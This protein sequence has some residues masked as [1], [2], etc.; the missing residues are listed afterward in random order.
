ML[1]R[2]EVKNFKCFNDNFV[3]DLT[4]VKN[5]EFNPECIQNG[6]VKKALIYGPNACGKSNLGLAIFDIKTHLS[7]HKIEEVYQQNYLNAASDSELAEFVYTFQ[8]EKNTVIYRY[9]KEA[10]DKLVYEQVE[11]NGDEVI[12]LDRRVNNIAAINLAGAETLNQ[13]LTNNPKISVLNYVQNNAVLVD[14]GTNLALRGLFD[15]PRLMINIGTNDAFRA[16]SKGFSDFVLDKKD[17]FRKDFSENQVQKLQGFLNEQGVTCKLTTL[18]S[19]G[20]DEVLAF[21]FG[22]KTLDL[23][24]NASSGT[25][26]LCHLYAFLLI[27]SSLSERYDSLAF[28]FIDEFDAFFHH[29]AA[30]SVMALLK[31]YKSQVIATTHNTSIMTNDL[32]RPDCYFIMDSHSAKPLHSFTDKELRKAHNIEKMYKAGAFN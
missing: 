32:L 5:Y 17:L 21:D 18:Q 10:V 30:L 14:N 11:I 19:D 24:N 3:L 2:F 4:D 12:S 8:F 26:S 1:R 27:V 7:D 23:I 22:A 6:I 9:G 28:L 29:H 13:D 31:E 25:L 15:F 16:S 20:G